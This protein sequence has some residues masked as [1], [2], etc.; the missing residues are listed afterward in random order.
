MLVVYLSEE[1]ICDTVLYSHYIWIHP[2]CHKDLTD[3]IYECFTTSGGGD[4]YQVSWSHP[5]AV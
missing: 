4:L 2:Q 1:S 5:N 3:V